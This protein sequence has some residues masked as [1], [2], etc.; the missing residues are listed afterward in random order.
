MPDEEDEEEEEEEALIIVIHITPCLCVCLLI[1]G[2][3][4]LDFFGGKQSGRCTFIYDE[5]IASIAI[6]VRP[7]PFHL[8]QRNNHRHNIFHR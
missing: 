2:V 6:T 1:D 3:F 7:L 4:P 5:E 8:H